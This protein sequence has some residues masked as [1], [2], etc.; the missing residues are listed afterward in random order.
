MPE[1]KT[2]PV[3]LVV[4]WVLFILFL[5]SIITWGLCLQVREAPSK[6]PIVHTVN[7]K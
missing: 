1:Y 4:L 7:K 5:C 6:G 2:E 3:G